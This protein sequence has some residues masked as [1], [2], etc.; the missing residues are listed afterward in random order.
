MEPVVFVHGLW[1]TGHELFLLRRRVARAGFATFRF[2]YRSLDHSLERNAAVLAAFVRALDV[3][4]V[5]FV[6]HSLGG[7]V[8]LRALQAFADLPPGRVVLLG[9][10]VRGSK[11]AARAVRS[12][13]TRWLI[14]AAAGALVTGVPPTCPE[15]EVGVIA[16]TLPL[17][18]GLLFGGPARPHDGT[19]AVEE[20]R[21]D[22][23]PVKSLPVTHTSLLVSPAVA[24]ETIRFLKE[25]MFSA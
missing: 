15:R 21:L 22:G 7:L 4:R 17:G 14:G 5:H 3:P 12:P 16:G 6:G 13:L 18:V 10:P 19:V 2:R 8:I 25:G 24:R 23:A 20:A 1:M 9:A 11:V